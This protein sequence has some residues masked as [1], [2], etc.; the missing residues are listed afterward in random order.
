MDH[1][2]FPSFLY[3]DKFSNTISDIAMPGRKGGKAGG[4]GAKYFHKTVYKNFQE[5][6][7]KNKMS[8]TRI[9]FCLFC[10]RIFTGKY[11]HILLCLFCS[12]IISQL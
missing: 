5:S 11:F 12:K 8:N 10:C 3:P 7:K 1:K 2:L 9:K 6:F 4:K